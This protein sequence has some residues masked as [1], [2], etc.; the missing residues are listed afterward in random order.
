M[1][2]FYGPRPLYRW[3]LGLLLLSLPRRLIPGSFGDL[4]PGRADQPVPYPVG[5]A[6]PCHLGSLPDQLLVL[7]DQPDVQSRRMPTFR[8]FLFHA[9]IVLPKDTQV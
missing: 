3:Q 9:R 5:Q 4:P 1:D 2:T 7:G 6:G 8:R